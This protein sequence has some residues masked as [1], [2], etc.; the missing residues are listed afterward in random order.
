MAVAEAASE[1]IVRVYDEEIVKFHCLP[2]LHEP[3]QDVLP[4]EFASQARWL[5]TW[6]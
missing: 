3:A 4:C 1:V 5:A 2:A 6:K